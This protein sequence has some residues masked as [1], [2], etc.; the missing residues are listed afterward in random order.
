MLL[1]MYISF[2]GFLLSFVIHLCSLLNI[3]QPPKEIALPLS[4]GIIAVFYPAWFISD[5]M[6]KD[7]DIKDYKK[8]ILGVCPKWMVI[9]NS[10]LIIYTFAGLLYLFIMRQF[11]GTVSKNFRGSSGY[12]MSLYFL[13]FTILYC[14]RRLKIDR[15]KGYID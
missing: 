2:I 3:Y 5:K 13:A 9:L 7:G 8:A 1:L 4:I 6:R 14:C 11:I 10:I 15:S 12:M